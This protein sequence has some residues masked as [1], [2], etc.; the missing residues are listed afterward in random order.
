MGL[1][2]DQIEKVRWGC[3]WFSP[4]PHVNSSNYDFRDGINHE[5]FI[6][7]PLMGQ[8]EFLLSPVILGTQ[9]WHYYCFEALWFSKQL[10][11]PPC[12]HMT[13]WP[14]PQKTS[15]FELPL[16]YHTNTL[17]DGSNKPNQ[18]KQKF[19][20]LVRISKLR[21]LSQGQQG[22]VICLGM[23]MEVSFFQF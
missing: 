15:A 17:A 6:P 8:W 5:G 1:S 12:V 10:P 2:F 4:L 23:F 14:V 11:F 13:Q 16:N 22:I 19:S 21:W 3:Y 7:D 18:I 20:I 9:Q